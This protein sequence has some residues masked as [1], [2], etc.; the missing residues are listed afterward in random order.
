[1]RALSPSLLLLCCAL[2]AG[3]GGPTAPP[4]GPFTQCP[5]NFTV[6]SPD[7]GPVV[8]TYSQPGTSGGAPPVTVACSPPSGTAL[9]VG[10][11]QITCTV[12]DARGTAA[13][14]TFEVR[15]LGPPRLDLPP[16][17]RFLAFGDS[18]TAG[19]ESQISLTNIIVEMPGSYPWHLQRMLQS[20]YPLQQIQVLNNGLGGETA[21]AGEQR[22]PRS[23]GIYGPRVLLLMEGTNDIFGGNE[24]GAQ[25][26]LTALRGMIRQGKASGVRVFLATIPPQRP[27]GRR[28]AAALFIPG[29]NDRIR[30][31]ADDEDVPLVDVYD[32]FKDRLQLIGVDD[33][34]P[35]PEG[36]EV[37]AQTFLDAIQTELEGPRALASHFR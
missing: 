33:L 31:L 3:C 27:G 9:A 25:R 22:L 37:M 35:T 15:V 6:E 10:T 8:V 19:E 2:I 26:A 36:Y 17:A 16:P 13:S 30:A 7:N 4:P 14:C 11:H 1:M 18:I 23:L 21:Q 32:A 29:F 12:T 5:A 24:L 20:R 28:N 34:H